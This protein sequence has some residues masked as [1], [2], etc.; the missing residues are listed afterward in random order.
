MYLGCTRHL[1]FSE[2]PRYVVCPGGS[3][4]GTHRVRISLENLWCWDQLGGDPF[5]LC[6]DQG[7]DERHRRAEFDEVKGGFALEDAV[8]S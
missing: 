6:I 3:Y 2:Q 1:L 7:A 4:S 5:Q 8:A